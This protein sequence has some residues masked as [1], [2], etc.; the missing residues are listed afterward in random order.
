MGGPSGQ[1]L[2]EWGGVG[3]EE[4]NRDDRVMLRTL[5][6]DKFEIPAFEAGSGAV[7]HVLEVEVLRTPDIFYSPEHTASTLRLV[8]CRKFRQYSLNK[9]GAEMAV[10]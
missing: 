2:D 1:Y 8:N 7:K 4:D 9:S 3:P 5:R 10:N 6:I